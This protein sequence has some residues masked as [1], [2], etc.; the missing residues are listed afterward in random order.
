M[1]FRSILFPKGEQTLLNK[2]PP[3]FFSDLNLDIVVDKISATK[4]EHIKLYFY[5]TLQDAES[6]YYRQQVMQDLEDDAIKSIMDAFVADME[7]VHRHLDRLD[8]LDYL[9]HKEGWFL[10]AALLYCEAIGK[11]RLGLSNARIQSPGLSDFYDYLSQYQ[12]SSMFQS[13]SREAK[14]VKQ[15]LSEVRYEI[16]IQSGKFMV[17][18]YTGETDYSSEVEKTFRRFK[19]GTVKDYLKQPIAIGGM[20]HIEAKI[21]EFVKLLFP[22]PFRALSKFCQEHDPF[23]DEI[24]LTFEREIHFYLAIIEFF[25]ELNDRKG[26]PFCYPII[27]TENR[28]VSVRDG[29]DIALAVCRLSNE[30][31]IV[32]NDFYLREPECIIIVTGP[33][34]GGKTTFARMFAQEHY[35]ASLG[36][37]VP[38]KEAKLVLFDQIFTHFEK[39]EDI[40]NLHGKLQDD[41]LRMREILSLASSKSILIVNEIFS[42]TSLEDAIELS[43]KV[44]LR[45]LEKKMLCVWVTFLDELSTMGE[46]VVSMVAQ[47]SPEDPA[48]RTYQVIRK[49]ADGLA[50]SMSLVKK[51]RLAHE[52]IKERIKP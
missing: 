7:R 4:P 38:G 1:A 39:E 25:S 32:C 36:C 8:Q 3:S 15:M 10:E 9:E 30:M 29:Y 22:E 33:N 23:I 44:V 35:F 27:N 24:I 16:I 19:Q 49:P 26:L 43:K 41:L 42:S 21:L 11:L 6:I 45:V 31:P 17:Q 14:A 18:K 48:I 52:Q 50:Y 51:H 20:N 2:E 12:R 5:T 46:R 34:Q 40:K 28:E 37:P 13:L 47:I